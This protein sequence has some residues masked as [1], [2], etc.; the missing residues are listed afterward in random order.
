MTP[1]TLKSTRPGPVYP[2][3]A[4]AA[5]FGSTAELKRNM[6]LALESHGITCDRI[7]DMIDDVKVDPGRLDQWVRVLA[8]GER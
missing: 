2:L 3:I 1:I 4:L 8:E 6:L 5:T 7:L